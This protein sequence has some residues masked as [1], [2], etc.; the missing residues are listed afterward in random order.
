MGTYYK[1]VESWIDKIDR[2]DWIELGV[3]RGE[4]STQWLCN[5]AKTRA[6]KF[7]GVDMDPQ[8][9][10]RAWVNLATSR[11][12]M[13][14]ADG[15]ITM[16]PGDLEPHVDLV[17]AKGEDFL[18]QY[19]KH[20]PTPKVSLVYLDNFDWDYWLGGQEELFVAGIKQRYLD[21][22]QVEMNNM[23][24][25]LT[26]LHQAMLVL[27][28]MTA[29]S[30]IICDDTWVMPHEGI[31]SGKCSAVVP[32]LL[33]HGFRILHSAGYRQNSGLILGRFTI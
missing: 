14:A 10:D 33:M 2:G 22:A 4:G 30:V 31:L 19:S 15:S 29:N 1:N 27:P 5:M 3:D 7:Y 17:L 32:F 11:E 28:L 13:I 20:L 18:N 26:H 8:Q 12:A 23:N 9:I 21:I 25:Q 24:S 16:C 6:T